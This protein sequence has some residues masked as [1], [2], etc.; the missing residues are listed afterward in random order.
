[1]TDIDDPVN[2]PVMPPTLYH[3][4]RNAEVL[5]LQDV[6][7]KLQK[8]ASV[9][10]FSFEVPLYTLNSFVEFNGLYAGIRLE[11]LLSLIIADNDV[12]VHVEHGFGGRGS[13][14]DSFTTKPSHLR[15]EDVVAFLVNF[16]EAQVSG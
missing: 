13:K 12:I 16:I 5:F 4:M 1:M 7:S 9:S 3:Y 6:V 8:V 15:S 14:Q 10:G 11:G 2:D